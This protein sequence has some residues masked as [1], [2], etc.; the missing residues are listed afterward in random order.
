MSSKF[1]KVLLFRMLM[2][3]QNK[4]HE[5]RVEHSITEDIHNG[6]YKACIERLM[7]TY[8]PRTNHLF[9]KL[10]SEFDNN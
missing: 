1:H 2:E 6:Q 4:I 7:A 5:T 8:K 3:R 10:K 9:V